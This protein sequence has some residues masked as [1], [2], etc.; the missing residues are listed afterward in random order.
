MQ[1]TGNGRITAF[2]FDT[3][4]R[5]GGFNWQNTVRVTDDQSTGRDSD[6]LQGG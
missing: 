4:F 3:P 2:N 6:T 1:L 5:F